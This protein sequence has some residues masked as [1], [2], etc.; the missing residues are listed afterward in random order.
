VR[1]EH[2]DFHRQR[3]K[4]LDKVLSRASN[5]LPPKKKLSYNLVFFLAFFVFFFLI[6]FTIDIYDLKNEQFKKLHS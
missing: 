3:V 6:C 4:Q 1:L 2:L 5:L